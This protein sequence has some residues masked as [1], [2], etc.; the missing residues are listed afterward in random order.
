MLKELTAAVDAL[1][2][3]P[4]AALADGETIVALHRQLERLSAVVARADAAFAA[5]QSWEADGARSAAAW[6]SVR[7]NLPVPSARRGVR[8][9]R[10]LGTMPAVE[11]AWLAG[12][13]G[14]AHAET[15]ARVRHRVE[16][17]TFDAYEGD[18]AGYARELGYREFLGLLAYWLQAT[19]PDGVEEDAKDQRDARGLHLSQSL[20]GMWFLDGVLDPIAGEAVSRV[21][22][23]IE[24]E[25]F[26]ADW[27]EAKERLGDE[28]CAADLARTPAQRR[29]DALVEMA[30]RAG[31]VPPGARLPQPLVT[32]LVGYETF[33]GRVCELASG[34]V[35]APGA[36]LPWLTEAWVE[37]VVFDGPDRVTNVGVRRRLFTGATRRAVEV[38]D[39]KCFSEFCD[40]PAEDCEIDH[41]VPYQAGGLTTD[42]NGRPA[43]SW[44]NRRRQC[45]P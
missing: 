37:R 21:V 25:L 45:P 39:R 27:A 7:C 38:R 13:I 43:C 44:H 10:A 12:D 33:A 5:T 14:E 22:K 34:T 41:V 29:S 28:V 24:T 36:L 42:S 3:V 6:I 9:G 15:L 17:E 18:L 26:E 1:G 16:A 31:S 19:D 2:G 11:E 20:D 8:L 30:R 4:P 40:E 23:V 32:V 35:V